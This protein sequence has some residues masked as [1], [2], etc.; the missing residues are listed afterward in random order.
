MSDFLRVTTPLVNKNQA[1]PIKQ[2][3]DP[4]GAFNIQSTTKVA[5]TQTQSELL[6]QNNGMIDTGEAPTLL[7]NLLKDPSVTASYLKNVFMLEE[8]YKLLPANNKTVTKE[9]EGI[10]DALLMKPEGLKEEMQ[11]QENGSTAFK[12]AVFDFLRS[13]SDKNREKPEVQ[14]AIARLLRAI[15]SMGNQRDILDSIGNN[16][17]FLRKQLSPS[18]MISAK[19]DELIG[20]FKSENA[21]KNFSDLKAEVLNLIKGIEDS[22][23]FSPKLGKILSIL[24]YNLSR[25]NPS[26]DFAG[27]AAFRLRQFLSPEDKKLFGEL[28]EKYTDGFKTGGGFAGASAERLA[29]SKVMSVLTDLISRQTDGKQSVADSAKMEQILHSLL[30]SPCN[31]TPLLHFILPLQYEDMRSFAEIWINPDS[32]EKDMPEGVDRGMHLLMV[33]DIDSVGRFEAEFF[34]YD[35]T[36]DFLLFCPPG[37]E[38]ACREMLKTVPKL[39]AGTEYHIGK[40]Q[41]APLENTRSLMEVFKSLP[42]RRVGVD[43]KI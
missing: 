35:K 7:L 42:Y 21:Q 30:S 25:Y 38:A 20:G 8:L 3:I 2:G 4:T 12:G 28:F 5:Q 24:T 15:N 31:F 16:L 17:S 10:F 19:L 11:K 9:I 36:I 6:K 23:L 33:V 40:T 14:F 13:V 41:A 1:V 39:T 32:D 34:V 27:E 26:S 29:D 37:S 22:V 43:V 18:K